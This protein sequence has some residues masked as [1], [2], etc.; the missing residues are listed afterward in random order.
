[1]GVF[2]GTMVPEDFHARMQ[3][4]CRKYGITQA[5]LIRIAILDYIERREHDEAESDSVSE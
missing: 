3:Q 2:I 1:M 5:A 4:F